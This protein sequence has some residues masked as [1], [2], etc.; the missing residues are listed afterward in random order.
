MQSIDKILEY[1]ANYLYGLSNIFLYKTNIPISVPPNTPQ[2]ISGDKRID[3]SGS[4]AG[5]YNENDIMNL[6][7]ISTGGN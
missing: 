2:V 1:D 6:T 7:C 5:V 4:F 3:T